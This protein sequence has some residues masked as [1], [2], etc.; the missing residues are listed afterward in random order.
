MTNHIQF[1]DIKVMKGSKLYE[2]LA[3]GKPEDLKKAEALFKETSVAFNKSW[4]SKYDHLRS[5]N[6]GTDLSSD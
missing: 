5:W 6:V 2:L 4:D 1:K 3:S